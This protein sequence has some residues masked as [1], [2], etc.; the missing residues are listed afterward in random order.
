[1]HFFILFICNLFNDAA[2]NSDYVASCDS[3]GINTELER[4]WK[5]A[6]ISYFKI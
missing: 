4:M 5:D 1:M 2:R 3:V 6:I